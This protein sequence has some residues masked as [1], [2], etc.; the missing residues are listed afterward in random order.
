[1][2]R[3]AT[4]NPSTDG[5]AASHRQRAAPAIS[6]L[7]PSHRGISQNHK[8]KNAPPTVR[9]A[10]VVSQRLPGPADG[11]IVDCASILIGVTSSREVHCVTCF[12]RSIRFRTAARYTEGGAAI[13]GAER[14]VPLYVPRFAWEMRRRGT[15]LGMTRLGMT[16]ED[17]RVRDEAR[18]N[19]GLPPNRNIILGPGLY[20]FE[21][22]EAF[23]GKATGSG[24]AEGQRAGGDAGRAGRWTGGSE[25]TGGS[26][27]SFAARI[28]AGR[29]SVG[30]E[31]GRPAA[32][33]A[34]IPHTRRVCACAWR[35][36]GGSRK[37]S[38]VC[39]GIRIAG[40]E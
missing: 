17:L 25:S 3:R 19:A 10:A 30:G 39:C 9:E 31:N 12:C 28:E 8:A 33:R 14:E 21:H 16:S 20:T 6:T 27:R 1:M 29:I 36:S 24:G 34:K 5:S 7:K 22:G 4:A 37:S 11:S 32:A 26:E 2:Q 40:C 23:H 13:L 18:I 15:P 38:R 35:G